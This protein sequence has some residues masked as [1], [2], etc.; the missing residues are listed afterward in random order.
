MVQRYAYTM[1]AAEKQKYTITDLERR[2]K[3]PQV[4][5]FRHLSFSEI[6][7]E[8]LP[9]LPFFDRFVIKWL[10]TFFQKNIPNF[11]GQTAHIS[12]KITEQKSMF[13]AE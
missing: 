5:L 10:I 1:S 2:E 12:G 7:K 8:P 3:T 13:P 6:W 4:P 9:Y 11:S